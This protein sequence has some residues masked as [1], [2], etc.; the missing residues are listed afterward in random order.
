MVA[1]VVVVSLGPSVTLRGA[2]RG[3][4]KVVLISFLFLFTA[5]LLKYF[6]SPTGCGV[7]SVGNVGAGAGAVAGRSRSNCLVVA[8]ESL[9]VLL[10]GAVSDWG[11]G[12]CAF[13]FASSIGGTGASVE[14]TGA[15]Y[16][17]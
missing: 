3:I 8:P 1:V 17:L 4:G 6:H 15:L 7:M 12:N 16:G 11:R 13:N 10:V 2:A 5:F 14:V 9:S